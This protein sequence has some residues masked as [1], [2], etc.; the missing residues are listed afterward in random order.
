VLFSFLALL[1]RNNKIK[2]SSASLISRKR[3]NDYKKK[4]PAMLAF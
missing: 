2:G 1:S 3:F 4:T